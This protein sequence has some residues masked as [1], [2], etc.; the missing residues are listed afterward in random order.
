MQELENNY[1][2]QVNTLAQRHMSDCGL[3]QSLPIKYEKAVYELMRDNLVTD[4][5]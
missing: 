1:Y 3:L 4:Q 2:Y 5:W